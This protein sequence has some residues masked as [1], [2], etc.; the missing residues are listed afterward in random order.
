MSLLPVLQDPSTSVR[1]WVYAELFDQSVTCRMA[2][3]SRYKLER[4]LRPSG[5]EKFFDL[6]MAEEGE[7]GEPLP[8]DELNPEQQAHY[9]AL[10]SVTEM[11]DNP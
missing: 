2:R 3:D 8:L 7:D 9:D 6:A 10:R 1:S 5:Q 4:N 11:P